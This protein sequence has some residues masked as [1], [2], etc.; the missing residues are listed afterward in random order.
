MSLEIDLGPLSWVKSEIDLALERASAAIDAHAKDPTRGELANAARQLHQAHGALAI[1]GLAG[2]SEFADAIE[3]L[4]VKLADGHVPWTDAAAATA[5]SGLAALRGYL[6]GLVG[7]EAN[8]P[9]KLMPAYRAL[10]LAAGGAEPSPAA[11]F[12][13][14][15]DQRPPR[16]DADVPAYPAD[17]YAARL[18]LARV[19]F[20]RGLLK[21]IKGEPR[22]AAEMKTATA[23]IEAAQASPGDRAFWWAGIGFFAAL[24]GGGLADPSLA[25]EVKR[26]AMRIGA[27]VKRVAGAPQGAYSAPQRLMAEV[28]YLVAVSSPPEK[29]AQVEVVRAAYRLHDALPR[30]ASSALEASR[31]LR[32]RLRELLAGAEEDWKKLCAGTAAALPP[33]HEKIGEFATRADTLSHADFGRLAHALG[34]TADTLR[35]DPARHNDAVALETATG[36]LLAEAALENFESLGTDFPAQVDAMVG[37]LDAALQGRAADAMSLPHLDAMSRRAQER[38]LLGTVAREIGANLATVEQTLDAFFRDPQKRDTLGE[39]AKPLAQIDGA[40]AILGEQRASEVLDQCRRDIDG[41]HKGTIEALPAAFE[42]LAHR[43]SALGFFVEQVESGQ[44]PDIDAILSPQRPAAAPAASAPAES[45]VPPR[46]YFE[47]GDEGIPAPVV[48]APEAPPPPP[49]EAPEVDAELLG[50]FLEEAREVLATI[51]EQLPRAHATPDDQAILTTLRRSF[52]TLKGSGRM[53]GLDGL[54]EVAWDV[55]QVMNHWLQSQLSAT[56]ELLGVLDDAGGV[57]GRWVDQLGAGQA[58]DFSAQ[59]I[60]SRCARLLGIE[61]AA[62][63]ADAAP[64]EVPAEPTAAD[65]AAQ[66]EKREQDRAEAELAAAELAAAELLAESARAR[67]NEAAQAAMTAPVDETAIELPVLELPTDAGE[68]LP[69]AASEAAAPLLDLPGPGIEVPPAAEPPVAADALQPTAQVHAFP[70]PPPV[71]IGDVE[72]SATLLPIFMEEAHSHLDTLQTHVND[73]AVPTDAIV[74]AAHTLSSTA[75]TTGI[76]AIHHLARG[77]EVA[78]TALSQAALV[79]NDTQRLLFARTVGA[80]DGMLGAVSARRLPGEE[81][82]LTT[83]LLALPATLARPP[84][85]PVPEPELVAEPAPVADE[86]PPVVAAQSESP[87]ER[88]AVRITDDIDFQ[89]LPIFLE[90]SVD[91]MASISERLRSWRADLGD[92][93]HAQQLQRD[94]HTLKGSARMAGAMGCGELL[95]SMET[96]IEQAV[97]LSQCTPELLDGLEVSYDRAAML[98]DRLRSGDHAPAAEE[99]AEPVTTPEASTVAPSLTPPAPAAPAPAAES[100]AAAEP[101][102]VSV[103]GPTPAPKPADAA[104]PST[105]AAQAAQVHLRVRADLVDRLVNEAGEVAIS[106]ARIEGEMRN[107]KSS[108]LELTDNVIRLR[109]QVR[110]IEIEAE[111]QMSSQLNQA[112]EQAQSEGRAFDPLEFDRFTRFQELTRFMAES[113]NDVA[114][115]QQNLLLNLDRADASLAHQGRLSRELS[116][117]L[118]GVRM[119]PFDSQAERLHRVVRQAAKDAGKRAN[120]DIRGGQMGI[121]RSVLEHLGGPLEHLLRNAVAHGLEDAAGR[122]AANKQALGQITISLAQEGNDVVISLAD[123]GGGLNLERIRARAIERGLLAA[124]AAVTE[125]DLVGMIFAAGFSTATEVTQLAGRGVGMDVVRSEVETLGGHIEINTT[126]GQGST[127]RL[128]LP[129]TL[130]VAQAVVIQAGG[131]PY[132]IPATM[133]E[134]ASEL[135]PDVIAKIREAGSIEQFGRHYPYHYLPNLLGDSKAHPHP[136]RRHWLML[137]KGGS[138]R[139]AVEI[140]AML[141]NQEIVLKAIGPQLSRIPGI[142]GATV[143]AEGDIALVLNPI[144]LTSVGPRITAAQG[145]AAPVP[146]AAVE[147]AAARVVMVVDDS[148]TVR[149]ITGRLLSRRGYEVATAKDGVDALE[150]MADLVPD[151]VLLDVE[152]PRMDGFELVRVM[153]NDAR[154]K[155]VP[156]VMITS[157]TADKHRQHALD[158][159][160]NHYLGKPF[161]ET[162]LLELVGRYAGPGKAVLA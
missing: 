105:L 120:L 156:I 48:S 60:Q 74:R 111:T 150:Q 131:R 18:K 146:V 58:P 69:D 117:R 3:N 30:S 113:V 80:L 84:A 52:H 139:V 160:A 62:T 100:V 16:R 133:I 92:M 21:W 121:D 35:R 39:L 125:K 135:K 25:R 152:M 94:L 116:E 154:L 4:F 144:A 99:S 70:A 114:T 143:L 53:V 71:M 90:E 155:T 122:A 145:V 142:A 103:H 136:A 36:L 126:A 123:D 102:A 128:F 67:D 38:L 32:R 76:E 42:P 104:R 11:L 147:E 22:G 93:R 158:L 28:L 5:Q 20:E 34:A 85:A 9:L 2:V 10:C 23:M 151:V 13:P 31:P 64:I 57:F 27:E 83:E 54:G 19:G 75:G 140:D 65:M 96:R 59:D 97:A 112:R 26:V 141:G 33:F 77:L 1:V 87:T 148:L 45:A 98:V 86:L 78:L 81:Q 101:V 37:R 7:G 56:P 24:F 17:K 50:I 29:L 40:L 132:A 61:S 95:H 14:D 124:D 88:R 15:L 46:L 106:R 63:P 82:A 68:A 79:P 137:V 44:K 8:Q 51:G 138:E 49:D 153:R 161:D 72:V 115:I 107:L 134:Q 73:T 55:E 159:G 6:D 130:A 89:V 66:L 91:L 119:V 157:R 118:M 162:V 47:G 12:F 110:E 127:F 109:A 149:K 108:L 41:L 43:L 129:L